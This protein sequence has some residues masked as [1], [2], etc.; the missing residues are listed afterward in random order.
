MNILERFS[1][2]IELGTEPDDCWCW[3]GTKNEKGYGRFW[4]DG[5]HVY[6]HRFSYQLYK[7]FIPKGLQLD[8]LCR[9]RGCCNP[10]HL[11][12]VTLQENIRRGNGDYNKFKTHCPQGHEY[13]EEN[14]HIR[15]TGHRD[16]R[17]CN[18]LR[19]RENRKTH[20]INSFH[21]K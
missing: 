7:G 12:A 4:L 17:V 19:E 20:N 13:N 2:K 9:N 15:K 14:T 18:K 6:T 16:C 21:N 8:H 10:D 11:E 3:V 1:D 5:K